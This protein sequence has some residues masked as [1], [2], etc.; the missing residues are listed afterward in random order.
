MY[1]N[2]IIY[3]SFTYLYMYIYF[4]N[5]KVVA[6]IKAIRMINIVE[7]SNVHDRSSSATRF[8]QSLNRPERL[9]YTA[10]F[11]LQVRV[12]EKTNNVHCNCLNV[13]Y[14]HFLC[15]DLIHY[16]NQ[17]GLDIDYTCTLLFCYVFAG[18]TVSPFSQDAIQLV[19]WRKLCLMQ[20]SWPLSM[21]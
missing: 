16:N 4:K 1:L 17:T 2:F 14:M 15:C 5:I 21:S 7:R 20:S 8:M 13:P 12:R 18:I 9:G 19:S 11:S 3:S 6:A 10:V